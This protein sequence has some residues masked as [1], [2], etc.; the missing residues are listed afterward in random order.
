M[1]VKCLLEATSGTGL[2][3]REMRWE[4][5]C[6]SAL[7]SRK[8]QAV[9]MSLYRAFDNVCQSRMQKDDNKIV[10]LANYSDTSM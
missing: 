2:F 7:S 6:P 3:S 5:G 9:Y 8:L 1:Q 10:L 4:R